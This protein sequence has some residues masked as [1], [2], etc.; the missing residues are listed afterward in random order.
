MVDVGFES[1][2]DF[3]SGSVYFSDSLVDFREY[4]KFFVSVVNR[5]FQTLKVLLLVLCAYLNLF[6]ALLLVVDLVDQGL[7]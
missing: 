3:F 2:F 7:I 5:V 6:D 4:V 1:G